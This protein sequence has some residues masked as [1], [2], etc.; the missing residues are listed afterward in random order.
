MIK[1]IR[2]AWNGVGQLYSFAS[3]RGSGGR[4]RCGNRLEDKTTNYA[5]GEERERAAIKGNFR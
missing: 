5:H 2:V 3:G 4:E 1:R